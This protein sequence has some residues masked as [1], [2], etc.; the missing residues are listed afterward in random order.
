MKER[1]SFIQ[2]TDIM[3]EKPKK[4]YVGVVRRSEKCQQTHGAP[5]IRF[6]A[7]QNIKEIY[8]R[9]SQ[10][11]VTDKFHENGVFVFPKSRHKSKHFYLVGVRFVTWFR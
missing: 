2:E 7:C 4:K 3:M 6:G 1:S 10:I 8:S 11:L 9:F 5:Q